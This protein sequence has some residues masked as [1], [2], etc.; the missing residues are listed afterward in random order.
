MSLL[1][2]MVMKFFFDHFDFT[3]SGAVAALV[4]GLLAKELWKRGIP[5][6]LSSEQPGIPGPLLTTCWPSVRARC[7]SE[8][9]GIPGLCQPASLQTA[10]CS[11]LC[12]QRTIHDGVQRQLAQGLGTRRGF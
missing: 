11:L 9:P 5:R 3:S 8:A 10:A 4:Q 2:V 1:A 7:V 6:K 12:M